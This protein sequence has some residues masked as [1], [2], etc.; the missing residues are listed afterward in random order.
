MAEAEGEEVM[1]SDVR[2]IKKILCWV[3]GHDYRW[4]LPRDGYISLD[5]PPPD[6]AQCKRCGVV[7]G[8]T[9]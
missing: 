8:D 9:I 6:H 1:D 2:M 7:Y 5:G 3:L 4:L